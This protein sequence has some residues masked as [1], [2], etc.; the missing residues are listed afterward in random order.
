MTIIHVFVLMQRGQS[1]FFFF[2]KFSQICTGYFTT[3]RGFWPFWMF[4]IYGG[5]RGW[6]I[7][8]RTVTSSWISTITLHD[9]T[10]CTVKPSCTNGP[11]W[12]WNIEKCVCLL[13]H[14]DLTLQLCLVTSW[15]S[16]EDGFGTDTRRQ[17]RAATRPNAPI[18]S[19]N[20]T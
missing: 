15:N 5:C 13:N 17:T 7:N 18:L 19:R 2:L 3:V 9:F 1:F 8:G 16:A 20:W 4:A 11:D 6:I 14:T 12:R 10:H